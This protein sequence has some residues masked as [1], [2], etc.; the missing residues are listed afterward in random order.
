M[1]LGNSTIFSPDFE[2]A[3]T[4]L[5]R[6]PVIGL[7]SLISRKWLRRAALQR[8]VANAERREAESEH[9]RFTEFKQS[10]GI[11]REAR[12]R[13]PG[14]HGLSCAPSEKHAGYTV[15]PSVSF[16]RDKTKH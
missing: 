9:G 2:G 7:I 11:R 13:E 12:E 10:P 4:R 1:G 16:L 8:R 15:L 3:L 14:V 6:A 5:K